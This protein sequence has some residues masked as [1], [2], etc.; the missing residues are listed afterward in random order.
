MRLPRVTHVLFRRGDEEHLNQPNFRG[1]EVLVRLYHL[2]LRETFISDLADRD[3]SLFDTRVTSYV[4]VI[5]RI[6]CFIKVP[7]QG[8]VNS[9]VFFFTANSG[10]IIIVLVIRVFI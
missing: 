8:A 4:E 3:P 7:R 10:V 9:L 6:N 5:I 2:I 1:V